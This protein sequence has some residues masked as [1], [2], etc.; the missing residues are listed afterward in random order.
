VCPGT[1]A[2]QQ[3]S[4]SPSPSQMYSP[5]WVKVEVKVKRIH[6]RAHHVRTML[7]GIVS[8]HADKCTKDVRDE[9]LCKW[10]GS[11]LIGKISCIRYQAT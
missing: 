3:L 10:S 4:Q 11:Q 6:L 1:S 5:K 8:G 2:K 9:V 7:P